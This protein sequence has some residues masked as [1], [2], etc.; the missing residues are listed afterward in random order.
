VVLDRSTRRVRQAD[1]LT[2]AST[3]TR[4]GAARAGDA[5]R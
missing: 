5:G 2:T 1:R 3:P 4:A